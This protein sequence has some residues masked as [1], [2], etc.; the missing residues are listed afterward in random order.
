MNE[1]AISDRVHIVTTGHAAQELPQRGSIS[2]A[3]RKQ[4]A[5]PV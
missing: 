4:Q 1:T 5:A 2:S 3:A